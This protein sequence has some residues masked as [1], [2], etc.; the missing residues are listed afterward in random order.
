MSGFTSFASGFRSGTSGSGSSPSVSESPLLSLHQ[1]V[2][3]EVENANVYRFYADKFVLNGNNYE[4]QTYKCVHSPSGRN[5]EIITDHKKTCE[6][7]LGT[8]TGGITGLTDGVVPLMQKTKAFD[9]ALDNTSSKILEAEF[10][11]GKKSNK[12]VVHYCDLAGATFLLLEEELITVSSITD[13]ATITT[14]KHGF[15]NIP[16]KYTTLITANIFSVL[17][18]HHPSVLQTV[19]KMIDYNMY[20]DDD[21][22]WKYVDVYTYMNLHNI[23]PT[24]GSAGALSKYLADKEKSEVIERVNKSPFFLQHAKACDFL[25]VAACIAA[26]L[27]A[28]C[29]ELPVNRKYRPGVDEILSN[30][31]VPSGKP[32]SSNPQIIAQFTPLYYGAYSMN[33]YNS[34]IPSVHGRAVAVM[35]GGSSKQQGGSYGDLKRYVGMHK[36]TGSASDELDAILKRSIR[37]LEARGIKLSQTDRDNIDG[38]IRLMKEQEEKLMK[39]ESDM[40]NILLS[41]EVDPNNAQYSLAAVNKKAEDYKNTVK[42]LISNQSVLFAAQIELMKI[43]GQQLMMSSA[44]T[45]APAAPGA[46]TPKIANFV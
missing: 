36:R 25:P 19:L 7:D 46:P 10:D 5:V 27:N 34:I 30:S 29:E 37:D 4:A 40:E 41:G 31:S 45:P 13:V 12:I 17:A 1:V 21:N 2:P 33:N 20:L 23:S 26:Y 6:I 15:E 18:K 11:S 44:T 38:R 28:N 39:F 32:G 9:V 35:T 24:V 3:N 22:N 42:K 16:A 8:T 14:N 43:Y